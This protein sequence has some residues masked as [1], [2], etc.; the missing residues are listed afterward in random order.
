[1]IAHD[2]THRDVFV[3][4]P[5]EHVME[6][7]RAQPRALYTHSNHVLVLCVS[8]QGTLWSSGRY[9][10]GEGDMYLI[11]AGLPHTME[12]ARGLRVWGVE[13]CAGCVEDP[14]LLE[15]FARVRAGA[16]A[17]ARPDEAQRARM[18]WLLHA[19]HE[20]QAAPQAGAEIIRRH[21]LGWL[22]AEVQRCRFEAR[23]AALPDIVSDALTYIEAHSADGLSLDALASALH[24]SPGYITTRLREATG[25]TAQ[26]WIIR[27]R[28]TEAR[29]RLLHTEE[30]VEIIADRVGYADVTHFIRMFK[31][32]HDG[33]TPAAWRRAHSAR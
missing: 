11:P 1:M 4:S 30:Q 26:E 2:H 5:D 10:L 33:L 23:D 7:A 15:P 27:F 32:H 22:L 14:A 8:G 20:E 28:M 9:T 17:A 16:A 29:R 18:L 13:L 21:A 19:L 25:S 12:E 31:R 6:I 3:R 24:K